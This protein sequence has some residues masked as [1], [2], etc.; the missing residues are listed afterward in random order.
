MSAGPANPFP[1][2]P[3]RRAIWDMLVTRDI[4]AFTAADWPGVAADFDADAFFAVDAAAS[5]NP[6]TWRIGY[7]TLDDY[8][9]D[10]LRQRAA[11][12]DVEDLRAALHAATTLRDIDIRGDLAVAHK[13]F[14]GTARRRDGSTLRLSWQSLYHCRRS[15]GRWRIAGFT[16]YLPNPCPAHEAAPSPVKTVPPHA[17]QHVTAGPYSPV[18]SVRPGRIVVISGQAA[19]APDGSVVGEDIK[20]QT[21]ATLDNC[22]AQLRSAGASLPDVFKVNVY[23]RELDDWA[24]F[25]AVY[26]ARVP[27]PRP[28]RTAV[29]AVLLPGLLV[30][31]EMW[32]VVA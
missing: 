16:G 19:L 10:W 15:E 30:E 24:A 3:D 26:G 22:E 12:A 17:G 14:D 23:L 4:E 27:E 8:R 25:N 6:D 20:T 13:K 5:P 21:E 7:A 29:G 32:A 9:D 31:V 11:L 18:L 2:D 1:N 28:V